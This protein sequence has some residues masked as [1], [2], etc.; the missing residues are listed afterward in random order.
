MA[1][2]VKEVKVE[3]VEE[4]GF[5]ILGFYNIDP[6]LEENGAK[7]AVREDPTG[8][9]YF[10]VRP[11][12]NTDYQRKMAE[13]WQKHADIFRDGGEKAEVLD[14]QLTAEIMAETVLVGA[15]GMNE[16]YSKEFAVKCM[17]NS[18]IRERVVSF[19]TSIANYRIK[20]EEV[21]EK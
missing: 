5:D 13:A 4:K 14:E 18:R 6:D 7:M 11:F 9:A 8:K 3:V 1:G 17:K 12:P 19:A 2:K 15:G 21:E 16:P 20:D 10:L